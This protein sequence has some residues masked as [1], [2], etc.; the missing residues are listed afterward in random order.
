MLGDHNVNHSRLAFHDSS[1]QTSIGFPGTTRTRRI[2]RSSPCGLSHC[3][4]II[5]IIQKA[6]M[7]LEHDH[8]TTRCCEARESTVMKQ[9]QPRALDVTSSLSAYSLTALGLVPLSLAGKSTRPKVVRCVTAQS[10]TYWGL[11]HLVICRRDNH[12]Q[13]THLRQPLFVAIV[14]ESDPLS[15]YRPAL[16]RGRRYHLALWV[17]GC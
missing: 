5:G 7:K 1:Q 13:E 11:A 12:H 17:D 2:S 3:V 14:L 6:Q 10:I 8:S 15:I 4:R 16:L 9:L